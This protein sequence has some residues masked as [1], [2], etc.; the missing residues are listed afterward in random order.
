MTAGL[1]ES[2]QAAISLMDDAAPSSGNPRLARD[3]RYPKARRLIF[4]F[5]TA[6]PG[7]E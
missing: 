7:V 3:C 2:L 6:M 4:D 1:P 5:F